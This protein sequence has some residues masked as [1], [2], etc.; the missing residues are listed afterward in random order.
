MVKSPS[1]VSKKQLKELHIKLDFIK[2]D[3]KQKN[4]KKVFKEIENLLQKNNIKFE[5]LEHKP[6]FTSEQAAKVRKT[7]LRQGA[8]A[9]LFKTDKGYMMAVVS[10]A[11]EIDTEKLKKL[12]VSKKI[13]LATPEEVEEITGLEIGAVP[14]FANLFDLEL[15]VDKSL[16]K[17]QVIAFNAGT[18]ENSIKMKFQ[19][20]KRLLNPKIG[21][22]SK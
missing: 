17:I 16:T 6:V 5:S 12:L 15:Y 7:K 22:F 20:Y 1:E 9:L 14:P 13:R 8:K 3:K 21:E 18:H 19:D 11:K 2:K 10:A 4:D